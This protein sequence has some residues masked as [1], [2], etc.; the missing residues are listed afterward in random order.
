MAPFIT[1]KALVLN[2]PPPPFSSGQIRS[3]HFS[4]EL[5]VWHQI[6]RPNAAEAAERWYSEQDTQRFLREMII[7]AVKCSRELVLMHQ[8][9]GSQLQ[10]PNDFAVRCVGLESLLSPDVRKRCEDKNN[11]KRFH[12]STVLAEQARQMTCLIDSPSEL[13]LVSHTS[14]ID[15]RKKAGLIASMIASIDD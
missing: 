8:S 1:N 2:L 9:Q 15:S 5:T 7:D 13:A 12:A 3:V 11:A 10:L 14:S 4:F 6:E